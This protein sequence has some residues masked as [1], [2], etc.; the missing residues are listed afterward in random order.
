MTEEEQA[1]THFESKLN[2]AQ[3]EVERLLRQREARGWRVLCPA[4]ELHQTLHDSGVF[5]ED[6]LAKTVEELHV[7]TMERLAVRQQSGAVA[8]SK[9]GKNIHLR[10]AT[11]QAYA[12]YMYNHG[13][14][15]AYELWRGLQ[16]WPPRRDYIAN[17]AR[18]AFAAVGCDQ[19]EWGRQAAV[20]FRANG[21][22]PASE[23]MQICFD[24]AKANAVA[25]WDSKTNAFVNCVD[26]STRLHFNSYQDLESFFDQAHA[27]APH[28][29]CMWVLVCYLSVAAT[30]CAGGQQAGGLRAHLPPLPNESCHAVSIYSCWHHS[31]RPHLHKPDAG[32]IS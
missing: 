26:F 17:R 15:S 9:G 6:P 19:P 28:R 31:D 8:L 30:L 1:S 12:T 10:N 27:H 16:L 4:A 23:P 7:L 32:E 25:K 14:S 13:S 18:G 2:G 3:R 20:Y 24:A 11:A 29:A 21:L 22:D 5:T